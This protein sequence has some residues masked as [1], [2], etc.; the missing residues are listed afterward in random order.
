MADKMDELAAS[1][2]EEIFTEGLYTR[3]SEWL[4]IYKLRCLHGDWPD[5]LNAA[6]TDTVLAVLSEA[7]ASIPFTLAR[8]DAHAEQI[9]ADVAAWRD[10]AKQGIVDNLAAGYG[11]P[12]DAGSLCRA[13]ASEG[14]LWEER[15]W[16]Y[17]VSL[18]QIARGLLHHAELA[19]DI[20]VENVHDVEGYWGVVVTHLWQENWSFDETFKLRKPGDGRSRYGNQRLPALKDDCPSRADAVVLL[21]MTETLYRR[22]VPAPLKDDD[23]CCRLCGEACYMQVDMR[24]SAQ[25]ERHMQRQHG[26][27]VVLE[28]YLCPL[29]DIFR[30]AQEYVDVHG[31][32]LITTRMSG[33]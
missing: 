4:S 28:E 32:Q 6:Q 5:W 30:A 23:P 9:L 25:A 21:E 27:A 31:G 16:G 24:S 17:D 33:R 13:S 29:K 14:V 20:R 12:A 10:S 26:K 3:F 22:N 11:L 15:C 19:F 7:N 18:H 1:R 8:F 2:R